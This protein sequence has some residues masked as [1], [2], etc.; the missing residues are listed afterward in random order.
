MAD[1]ELQ[2]VKATVV[3]PGAGTENRTVNPTPMP[4]CVEGKAA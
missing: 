1:G 4:T 2:K 3:I